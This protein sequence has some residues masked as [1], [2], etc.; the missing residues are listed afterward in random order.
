M[1]GDLVYLVVGGALLVAVVLPN[2]LERQAV[3][4]PMVLLLVGML[5]GLLPLPAHVALSPLQHR[6]FVEHLTE[7]TVVVALMGVGLALDRPLQPRSWSSWRRWGATWRLLAILTVLGAL[8]V[9]VAHIAGESAIVEIL[10]TL[11][12]SE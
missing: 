9:G 3:S 1:S 8:V 4:A 12:S 10:A 6:G 5:I 7:L 2:V 11:L